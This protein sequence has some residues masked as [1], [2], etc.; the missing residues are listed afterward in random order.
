MVQS[1]PISD[2]EA[3][4][5]RT[6]FHDGSRSLVSEDAGWTHGP[7]ANLFDIGGTHPAGSDANEEFA[8][9]DSRYGYDF[10]TQ[11]VD[12]VVHDGAHFPG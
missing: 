3:A 6:E 11:I 2:L 1:D 8:A 5:S 7:V 12:S 10:Q 9:L 4:N